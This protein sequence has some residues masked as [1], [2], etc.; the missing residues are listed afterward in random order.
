VRILAS[1]TVTWRGPR[2]LACIAVA[3]FAG[4]ASSEVRAA[5]QDRTGQ[6]LDAYAGGQRSRKARALRAAKS[7][8][9]YCAS[10][11]CPAALH[12][13]CG[14]WFDEVEA[15]LPTSLFRVSTS[16]GA[17]LD[18]VDIRIDGGT[19]QE[20]DGQAVAV[21]PGPHVIV[22]SRAGYRELERRFTFSESE[23]LTQNAIVLEPLSLPQASPVNGRLVAQK[24]GA[25]ADEPRVGLLPS[26][27]G[28]GIGAAGFVS[29][30]YFGT[31]ARAGDRAL[32]GCSPNCDAERVERVKRE[33]LV[34]NVSAGIGAAGL[35]AAAAWLIFRPRATPSPASGGAEEALALQ[36]GP[37][38]TLTGRF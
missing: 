29:F 5:E 2:A 24:T 19:K 17:P 10:D 23:K 12:A 8:F 4:L 31:A 3:C 7:A 30:A 1:Q 34:A 11:S 6:C 22:F 16:A 27:I 35:L 28:A 13:D 37:V 32:D 15:A 9:A 20:L 21:D 25:P 18:G 36:L 33:Y 26:W 14:R 38:S